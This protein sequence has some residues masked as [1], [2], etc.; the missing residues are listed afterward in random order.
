MSVARVLPLHRGVHLRHQHPGHD[1]EQRRPPAPRGTPPRRTPSRRPG[2]SPGARTRRR[3][4]SRRRRGPPRPPRCP[5]DRANMFVPV[6]TPRSCHS[7]L[8]WA[9]IS[10]GV[11][12]RP[13]PEAGDEAGDRDDGHRRPVRE[14]GE[15]ARA[16]D[17]QAEPDQDR[18]AEAQPQVEQPAGQAGGQRPAEGQGGERQARDQRR[19]A[20]RVLQVGRHVRGQPD[21]DDADAQRQERRRR[22]QPAAEAPTAA[23]PV[24]RRAARP[25]RRRRAGRRRRRTRRCSSAS[26]R[27]RP[28][29]PR[30]PRGGP[31]SCRWSAGRRRGSRCGASGAAPSRGSSAG[32]ATPASRQSGTL[33][34]KIQRHRPNCEK[35]PP[36]VGPTT[37]EMAQTLAM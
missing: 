30:G 26:A 14:Q 35:T 8:A 27:P 13:M 36:R 28:G 23:A 15:R 3:P 22:E 5:V 34:R 17:D 18:R 11:A 7:T 20:E 33:T 25:A 6:A 12:T 9:A 10:D 1:R 24:R 4:R 32:S 31:G 16:D 37:D 2:R 29:R 19:H 21:E